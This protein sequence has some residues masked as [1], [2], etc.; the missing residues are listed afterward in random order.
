MNY[1]HDKGYAAEH[2]VEAL[3]RQSFPNCY[4]PRAGTHH[5]IGDI[6]NVPFVVSVKNHA[7]LSLA[8]WCDDLA[9]MVIESKLGTGV[10]WHK[11]AGRSDPLN[12]YVTTTGRLWL[13]MALAYAEIEHRWTRLPGR[14][15]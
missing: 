10:V 11:R 9:Q 12:W 5:D 13:P 1:S 6:G 7:R 8:S 2:A 15:L 4:R 14:G 3:L